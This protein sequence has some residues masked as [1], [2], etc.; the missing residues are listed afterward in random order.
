MSPNHDYKSPAIV[1]LHIKIL[2][3]FAVPNFG[4]MMNITMGKGKLILEPVPLNRGN[5]DGRAS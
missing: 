5:S 3:Q 1:V 2:K 4:L